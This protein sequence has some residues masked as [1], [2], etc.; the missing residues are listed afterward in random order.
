M[1]KKD[2]TSTETGNKYWVII[3]IINI[4]HYLVFLL[5]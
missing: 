2:K 5:L 1:I 4:S 3:I